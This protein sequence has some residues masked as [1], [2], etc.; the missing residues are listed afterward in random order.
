MLLTTN[1]SWSLTE[2]MVGRLMREF[3]R[4]GSF[5]RP[6]AI[7]RSSEHVLRTRCGLGYRAPYVLEL[8]RSVADGSLEIESWRRSQASTEELYATIGSVKGFGPYAAGNLLKLLGR[9]D[10][11]GLD[12]WVRAQYA[13][14]YGGGRRASDRAIERRYR[15]YG[16]WRGLVFWLEMTRHWHDEKF[17]RRSGGN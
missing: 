4:G 12:S 15:E 8:A 2:A 6:E 3:G 16:Q 14:L 9:Y 7:A 10:Y 11:L 1:C 17:K 5:P 13:R